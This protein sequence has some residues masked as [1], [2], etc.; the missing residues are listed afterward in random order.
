MV[1]RCQPCA[2]PYQRSCQGSAYTPEQS[3]SAPMSSAT[4]G[5]LMLPTAVIGPRRARNR[6]R[7]VNTV[8]SEVI[9]VP[10]SKWFRDLACCGELSDAQTTDGSLITA[11][12]ARVSD[13]SQ[14]LRRSSRTSTR[15]TILRPLRG[16]MVHR[17]QP[18]ARPHQRRC[19]GSA[20][21]PEQSLQTPP[22]FAMAAK[23]ASLEVI[24]GG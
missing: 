14:R 13:V 15:T 18:C 8:S 9:F 5:R 4:A 12:N 22:S 3:L 6:H 11:L 7:I 17:C 1:H 10:R 20:Y 24:R 16:L 23:L 2:R 21:T 19:R